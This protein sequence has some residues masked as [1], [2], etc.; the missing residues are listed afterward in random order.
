MPVASSASP[1]RYRSD[2]LPGD[3]LRRTARATLLVFA[4]VTSV[5]AL[6]VLGTNALVASRPG[7]DAMPTAVLARST[8][9]SPAMSTNVSTV[10]GDRRVP[11]SASLIRDARHER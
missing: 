11:S 7:V 3:R 9:A 2:H 4:S 1:T 8:D 6:M 10:S 5:A